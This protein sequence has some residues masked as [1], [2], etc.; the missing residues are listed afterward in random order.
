MVV[1]VVVVLV[2]VSFTPGASKLFF[3]M[4]PLIDKIMYVR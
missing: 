1:V 4:A 3:I 2:V